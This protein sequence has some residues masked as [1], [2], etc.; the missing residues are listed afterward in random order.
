[1]AH[2]GSPSERLPR[3]GSLT[4][5]RTVRAE[6]RRGADDAHD[7]PLRV[8]VSEVSTR[9]AGKQDTYP[10]RKVAEPEAEHRDRA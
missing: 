10:P 6:G 4:C 3:P 5:I 1:M 8:V 2:H 9:V 7:L